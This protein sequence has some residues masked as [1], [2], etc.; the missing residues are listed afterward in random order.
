MGRNMH[1]LTHHILKELSKEPMTPN[2]IAKRFRIYW[3]TAQCHLLRLAEEGKVSLVKN[4][5]MNIFYLKAPRILRFDLPT[6]VMVRSLRDI[7]NELEKYLPTEPTAAEMVRAD[8]RSTLR[9]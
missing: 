1:D 9:K 3:S 7:S 5:R 6:W 8:R 4:G 2:E